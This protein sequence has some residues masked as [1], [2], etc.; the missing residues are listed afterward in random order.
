MPEPP[1]SNSLEDWILWIAGIILTMMTTLV[2][3]VVTLTRLVES[4]YKEEVNNLKLA[5]SELKVELKELGKHV[6][7]C[8]RE[9]EEHRIRIAS[10]EAK[11]ANLEK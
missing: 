6:D 8:N 4:K 3:T 2:G 9:R 1:A 11:Y 10:L 7:D 5:N